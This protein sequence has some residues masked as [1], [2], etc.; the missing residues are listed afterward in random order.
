MSKTRTLLISRLRKA[1]R[2]AVI[3]KQKGITDPKEIA[4]IYDH[5]ESRRRFIRQAALGSLALTSASGLLT[6][7]SKIEDDITAANIAAKKGRNLKIAII[8]GG[9]AGLNCAYQLSKA[10]INS[11]IFEAS[12]RTGGRIYTAKNLLAPG[13]TTELGGEFIDITS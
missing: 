1:F 3:A 12:D 4:D 8:G 2:L 6:G 9:M 10:G 7:C 11:T 13:I 5:S